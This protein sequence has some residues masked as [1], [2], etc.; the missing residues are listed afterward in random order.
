MASAVALCE[1]CSSPDCSET[2][3]CGASSD[4]TSPD[5]QSASTDVLGE[6]AADGRGP[7]DGLADSTQDADASADSP[8]ST[9]D[10]HAISD[11]NPADVPDAPDSVSP[12]GCVPTGP[13]ICTD[14]IDNDCKNGI[15][16]ADP[17]CQQGYMCVPAFPLGWLAPVVLYD[18]S[19]DSGAPPTA[20]SCSGVG[21][22]SVLVM[23]G[24]DDIVQPAEG[25]CTCSCGTGDAGCSPSLAV[26]PSSG[27]CGGGACATIT[28]P[29]SCA[30]VRCPSTP[31]GSISVNAPSSPGGCPPSV[32]VSKPPWDPS[33]GWHGTARACGTTRSQYFQGGCSADQVCAEKPPQALGGAVCLLLDGQPS[34]PDS[35]YSVVHTIYDGGVDNRGC[36]GT[37]SC[38]PASNSCSINVGVYN[39]ASCTAPAVA[40]ITTPT[41]C[42]NMGSLASGSALVT[43]TAT[44]GTCTPSGSGATVGS[45][46]PSGV[47]TVCCMGP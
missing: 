17:A 46:S 11:A 2:A 33:T 41:G 12:D 16:C 36:S 39:N 29:T 35:G 8:D 30:T 32:A 25:T 40:S 6:A 14:N 43:A 44:G 26:L 18:Q 31:I 9:G 15:D 13:E 37:C 22:Y 45:V 7:S 5:D 3:T 28:N 21:S 24:H 20:P 10:D 19:S 4:A 1:A 27:G 34:C 47:T 38:G 42:A 23:D